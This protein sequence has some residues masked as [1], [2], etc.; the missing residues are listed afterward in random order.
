MDKKIM[1]FIWLIAL[2]IMLLALVSLTIIS[3][4]AIEKANGKEKQKIIRVDSCR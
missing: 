3:V 2:I 4:K 1:G